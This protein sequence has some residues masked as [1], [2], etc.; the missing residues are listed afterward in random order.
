MKKT[1]ITHFVKL[2]L[3]T[4]FL[5]IFLSAAAHAATYY[6][7]TDGNNSNTGL[8]NDSAGA[9]R[10]IDYAADHVSAG[11]VVR[12]QA[13]TYSERVTPGVNGS[14]V[15]N[16]VTFVAD[17][18]VTVCGWNF[19]NNSFIRVIGFIIKT[20]A[21][22]C[23]K[24]TGC[25][26]VDGRN[27]YLEFWNNTFR[28]ATYNGIRGTTPSST[29][30]TSNSLIIGNTF[31]NLGIGNGSGVAVSFPIDNSLVAY[32]EVYN[33]HPDGFYM[34]ARHSR[35]LNNYT[36]DLSE[37][38]GGH[39]DVFQNGASYL[40]W[41]N[42]LI[43]GTLQ[44]GLGTMGDEHTTIIQNAGTC[45]GSCGPFNNNIFRRNVWH[46]VSAGTIGIDHHTAGPVT[47]TYIYDNTTAKAAAAY[48]TNP[49][50][51]YMYSGT[52]TGTKIYNNL[53]YENWGSSRT[54]GVQVYYLEGG[55]VLDYNL[56]YSPG[57][58][59]TFASPWTTQA[60]PRSNVNPRFV[61]YANDNFLLESSSGA[62]GRGGP[63]TATSGSGTGTTF[64]VVGN[65]GG[66]FRGDNPN[67]SQYGGKLVVG[68]T[69]TVGNDTVRISSI[70]GD[71]ITVTAPFTWADGEP[72][73]YGAS[74]T[75]DIGAYPYRA[76]G[77]G[78]TATYSELGG[79]VRVTPS[80][81]DLV[82]FVVCYEDGIPTTVANSSPYTC[83]VGSGSL[84]V[85]VYP[86]YPSKTLYVTATS[87]GPSAPT[88]LR[89]V[90]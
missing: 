79:T 58:S 11:D 13:G 73:Y 45:S 14:S 84:D 5:V 60:H 83:S 72:V 23:S 75:P 57:G 27:S 68:D 50:G 67:L 20:D 35:W 69:I 49:A 71:S 47:N 43:E 40:G 37:A 48:P 62:I 3:L 7:R 32:N 8:T 34:F 54:T 10:T 63:L 81:P 53:E 28:D 52:I 42:N 59:V 6:V 4:M 86:L 22:N 70:S 2:G 30:Y 46:N 56:A 66:F 26:N 64:N 39:S 51:V 1:N 41:E 19:L 12:V 33:S 15:T 16:T 88:N 9:W 24:S 65:G 21:G 85:R 31:F 18:S 80:A 44:M 25:V 77:Y 36:H 89:I 87:G 78:L 55:Y 76:G 61:N 74:A 38:S 29:N 90:D 17:G 82:R